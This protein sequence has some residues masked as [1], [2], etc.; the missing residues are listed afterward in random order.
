MAGQGQLEGHFA[1][2]RM[3]RWER[4]FQRAGLAVLA[5]IVAGASVGWFGSPASVARTAGIYALLLIVFRVSGR[6]TLA[7]VTNFDLILVLI[8]GDV[9]QQAI[10]GDDYTVTTAIVV[11]AT[12]VVVDVALGKAKQRWRTVDVIVDGLPLPLI[13]HGKVRHA[14]MKAEG[15]TIEDV[16]T[17]AREVHGL[18]ST[19]QIDSAVLE[20]HGGIS[21]LPARK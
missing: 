12:L 17:A 7:Q 6:R 19:A 5:A 4:R 14:Q 2:E 15:V 16:L 13:V 9:T 1:D 20:Q 10:V 11:I 3:R 21:V 8:L 18:S